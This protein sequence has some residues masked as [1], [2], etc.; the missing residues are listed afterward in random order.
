MCTLCLFRN[1]SQLQC[2]LIIELI[3]KQVTR[4]YTAMAS[5]NSLNRICLSLK[6]SL[7]FPSGS[8]IITGLYKVAGRITLMVC[9]NTIK[10]QYGSMGVGP[11]SFVMVSAVNLCTRGIF[12]HGHIAEDSVFLQSF[13][14]MGSHVIKLFFVTNVRMMEWRVYLFT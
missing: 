7:S 13:K 3:T 6:Y 5:Y 12:L 8:I 14:S 1:N 9:V 2:R 4:F 11:H 10:T